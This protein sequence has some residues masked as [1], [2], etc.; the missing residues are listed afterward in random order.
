M[1][2][3]ASYLTKSPS[4]LK[5]LL[6]IAWKL[7]SLTRK[8]FHDPFPSD[9]SSLD[10]LTAPDP[11]RPTPDTSQ[12]E[13]LTAPHATTLLLIFGLLHI[14]L[15]L[16]EMPSLP[17]PFSA[18]K[19]QLKYHLLQEASLIFPSFVLFHFLFLFSLWAP[20]DVPMLHERNTPVPMSVCLPSL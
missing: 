16:P 15:C 14:Q 9:C 12:Q 19:I 6:R 3:N 5:P 20:W 1:K 7:L 10:S 18:F 8:A 2:Q 17:Q 4:A 13:L 11:A